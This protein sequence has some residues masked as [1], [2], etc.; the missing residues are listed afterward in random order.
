MQKTPKANSGMN[1]LYFIRCA[2][3][4]HAERH[5]REDI[6][7]PYLEYQVSNAA[8]DSKMELVK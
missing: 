5:E 4:Y 8:R 7:K 3:R 2:G 6:D 1:L